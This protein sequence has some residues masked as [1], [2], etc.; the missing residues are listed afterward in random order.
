[1]STGAEHSILQHIPGIALLGQ[2]VNNGETR[3]EKFLRGVAVAVVGGGLVVASK[4]AVSI[5][6]RVSAHDQRISNVEEAV[7]EMSQRLRRIETTT[8]SIHDYLTR[9]YPPLSEDSE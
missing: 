2:W 9:K 4:W 3:T 1:M 6:T 7:P 5:E 8:G